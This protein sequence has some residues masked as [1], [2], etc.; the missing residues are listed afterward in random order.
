MLQFAPTLVFKDPND[1]GLL[2]LWLEDKV[3]RDNDFYTSLV[4]EDTRT[5]V[6]IRAKWHKSDVDRQNHITA[7]IYVNGHLEGAAHVYENGQVTIM[8]AGDNQFAEWRD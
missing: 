3:D 6:L 5:Y 7:D 4:S 1:K 8:P 2:Q